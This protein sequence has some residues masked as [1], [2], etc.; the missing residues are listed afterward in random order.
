[1]FSQAAFHASPTQS[2]GNGSERMTNATCGPKCLE[3]YGRFNRGG[4]LAKTFPALLIGMAGWCSTKCRLTWKLRATKSS[5]LYFQLAVSTLPTEGIGSGLLPTPVASENDQG[6]HDAIKEAGSSWKGQNR[7]ATVTTMAKAGLLPTPTLQDARIGPNN[8]GGSQH[9]AERGSIALADIAL[10]LLPTPTSSTG[11][12]EPAGKTGRKLVTVVSGLLPTPT[13]MDTNCGDLQKIDQRREKAKQTSN[14][15]NG[16]GMTVG[17]LAN[18]GLLP[19]PTVNDMNNASLPPS[20]IYRKDSIVK[21]VL[22]HNPEAGKTSQLNPRFV[23]E[24]MGFPVNWTELPFLSGETKAS[25][26]TA[27]P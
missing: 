1:M 5:R 25:K 11:G 21:R 27:T 10:G 14:N 8:I 2:P 9:R 24:M 26:P 16:F 17:E 13:V 4:S 23:A 15:G 19:T 7:G 6:N 18:R 22:Q 12:P 3:Q 20:Q